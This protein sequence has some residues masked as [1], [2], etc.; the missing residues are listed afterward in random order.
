MFSPFV[1]IFSV[2]CVEI[3]YSIISYLVNKRVGVCGTV[4]KK[5]FCQAINK[6]IDGY[7]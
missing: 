3:G 6:L 4:V 2:L 7:E 5:C 1:Y